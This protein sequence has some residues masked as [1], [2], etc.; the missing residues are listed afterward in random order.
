ME[1]LSNV[2]AE[3]KRR[4]DG[5]DKCQPDCLCE[6]TF[7]ICEQAYTQL[8]T[9]KDELADIKE[10][11]ANLHEKNQA[12]EFENESQKIKHTEMDKEMAIVL[13]SQKYSEDRIQQLLAQVELLEVQNKEMQGSAWTTIEKQRKKTTLA[14]QAVLSAPPT[15]AMGP[16]ANPASRLGST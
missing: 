2:E 12:L 13:N 6:P 8:Q 5:D 3:R 4:L 9:L 10:E 7:K 1:A 14:Q 16:P 15:S 11:N